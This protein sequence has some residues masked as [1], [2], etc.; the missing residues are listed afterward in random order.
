MMGNG[1]PRL[2]PFSKAIPVWR[3]LPTEI[4]IEIQSLD[5]S[6]L[7]QQ[8]SEFTTPRMEGKGREAGGL[9]GFF[10]V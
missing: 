9:V 7:I 4:P 5:F 6:E 1:S 2:P 10:P 8:Q 3:F